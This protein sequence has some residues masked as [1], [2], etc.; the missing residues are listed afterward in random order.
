MPA[1]LFSPT[2]DYE[3]RQSVACYCN[4]TCAVACTASSMNQAGFKPGV[5]SH[6]NFCGSGSGSG[7]GQ[8][9]V[10]PGGSGSGSGSL[11]FQLGK[12]RYILFC[13]YLLCS[14]FSAVLG[15]F[16]AVLHR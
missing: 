9:G 16:F 3:L 10:A 1:M 4:T 7:S 6:F 2:Y 15:R 12:C 11:F 13:I 14:M 5:W 8:N